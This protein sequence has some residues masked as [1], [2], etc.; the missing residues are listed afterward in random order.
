[1]LLILSTIATE[2]MR[3][4]WKAQATLPC[5]QK[6]EVRLV[7]PVE[8]S[9]YPAWTIERHPID[10]ASVWKMA[11][12]MAAEFRRKPF[13]ILQTHGERALQV[14]TLMRVITGGGFMMVHALHEARPIADNRLN[15]WLYDSQISVC[16]YFSMDVFRFYGRKEHR[17]LRLGNPAVVTPAMDELPNRS[18]VF[19]GI[20]SALLAP[21]R[22]DA[23]GRKRVDASRIELSYVQHFYVSNDQPEAL[24]RLLR[25]AEQ[26]PPEL[27]D[28]MYFV[29]VDDGS[30]IPYEIPDFSLNFIWLKVQKD[31]PWNEEGAR[32]LGVVYAKSD[33]VLL[34][35]LDHEFPVE[36]LRQLAESGPCGRNIYRFHRFNLEGREI[37]A[38]A[39]I[40]FLSRARY[41]RFHG[42]D[43]EFAGGY[44]AKDVAFIKFQKYQGSRLKLFGGRW[45][46]RASCH[47]RGDVDQKKECH[48]L[49]RDFTVNTPVHA[50][51]RFEIQEYGR[52]SGHSREFLDFPFTVLKQNW[53]PSPP[54]F[55][56]RT[57]RNRW[58]KRCWLIRQILPSP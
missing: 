24:Y 30:P 44:G 46:T 29:L 2:E 53:R 38:H 40:F 11:W 10:S 5:L 8:K 23:V 6:L 16:L 43:E 3:R 18:G 12:R 56:A 51:K 17:C 13:L 25:K 57:K 45:N 20:F 58:W 22:T 4:V 39:N 54:A 42:F 32:N 9:D 33:N 26:Y 55:S 48:D 34:S 1:M 49:Q 31:I 47:V 52:M 27:L 37:N 35:D 28:R 19:D 41:V 36:T 50:R 15:R 14:A 7:A 21:E